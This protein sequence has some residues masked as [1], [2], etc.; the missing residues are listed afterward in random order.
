MMKDDVVKIDAVRAHMRDID[1][2]LLRENLKLNFEQ[3]AQKHLRALQMVEELRRAGKK[4]RQK[5]DG[6]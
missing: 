3:R 2:T 4:L 5:S 6:R 1:R